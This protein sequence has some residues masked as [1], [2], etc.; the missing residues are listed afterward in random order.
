M[1]G[2]IL[3]TETVDGLREGILSSDPSVR[4]EALKE[5]LKL[6]TN[7]ARCIAIGRCGVHMHII[8]MYEYEYMC[9]NICILYMYIVYMYECMNE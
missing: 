1:T 8:Y 7:P 3:T 9:I 4:D 2:G 5:I 6:A